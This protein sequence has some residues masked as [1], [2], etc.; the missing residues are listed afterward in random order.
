MGTLQ[1]PT[2][3]RRRDFHLFRRRNHRQFFIIRESDSFVFIQS[4]FYD[5]LASFAEERAEELAHRL[6]FYMSFFFG[7]CHG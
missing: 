6:T 7:S 1:Y 3:G 2:E 5:F 4:K